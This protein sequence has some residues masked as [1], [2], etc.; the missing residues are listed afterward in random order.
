MF[1]ARIIAAEGFELITA[2]HGENVLERLEK[3]PRLDLIVLDKVNTDEQL[4]YYTQIKSNPNIQQIPLV[5]IFEKDSLDNNLLNKLGADKYIFN[6]VDV[7]EFR[8]VLISY[9]A[10][11]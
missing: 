9:F 3:L 4:K 6:P 10:K 11:Q 8:K 1:V 2:E 7:D 5:A